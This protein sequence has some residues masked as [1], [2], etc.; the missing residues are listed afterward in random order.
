MNNAIC[1]QPAA[2]FMNN[3]DSVFQRSIFD[4]EEGKEGP[5]STEEQLSCVAVVW[6]VM[7]LSRW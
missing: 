7:M 2:D 3:L 4:H 1:P 5:L 6:R